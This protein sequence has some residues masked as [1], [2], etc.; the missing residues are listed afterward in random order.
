MRSRAIRLSKT[1]LS[2][3]AQVNWVHCGK[4]MPLAACIAGAALLR[5][6]FD[7]ALRNAPSHSLWGVPSCAC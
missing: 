2:R 4:L 1:K 7:P 5:L 6:V 3:S